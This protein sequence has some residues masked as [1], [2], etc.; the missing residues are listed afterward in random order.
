MRSVTSA[1][2]A[3]PQELLTP[4]DMQAALKPPEEPSVMAAD[5]AAVTAAWSAL[6]V[7]AS[8]AAAAAVQC[9]RP[10]C[11][12]VLFLLWAPPSGPLPLRFGAREALLVQD[13]HRAVPV[14]LDA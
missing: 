1:A 3:P 10:Q 2:R 13:E 5:G 12:T 8:A 9:P 4:N 7:A 6:A 11:R 14:V